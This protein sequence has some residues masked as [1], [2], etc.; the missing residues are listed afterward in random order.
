MPTTGLPSLNAGFFQAPAARP[1]LVLLSIF[2][3]LGSPDGW[4]DPS[5]IDR[6]AYY[7]A[8]AYCRGDVPRP[9]SV[10]PD[11]AVLCFDGRI[12]RHL[13]VS[14]AKGL[15][16]GGLFVV[17]SRGGNSGPSMELSNLVRDHHATVVVYDYCFSACA[18]FFF[19]AS[20]QTYVLRDT[21]VVWHNPVSASGSHAFCNSL[22]RPLAGGPAKLQR[23][24]CV[25][26]T[27]GDQAAYTG[28]WREVTKFFQDRAV[29]PLFEPPPDS[30]HVRRIVTSLYRET[31][32]DHDVG[33]TI[34][35]R[36]YPRLF[37]AKIF[38]EAYPES[39]DEVDGM[40]ARLHEDWKVIYDP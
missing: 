22:T 16:E 36:Y 8:V 39:Q 15:K 30:I 18:V 33:W 11:G 34:H 7:Q 32:I 12:S 29:N 4:A 31:G 6:E 13:D 21:L 25:D 3:A 28:G 14:Q 26:S 37:K 35:P 5:A 20:D 38:Y 2:M 27:F 19:V 1:L 10:S 23:G 17:R 24:P 40:L 9:M